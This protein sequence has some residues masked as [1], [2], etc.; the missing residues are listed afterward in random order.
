MIADY[1]AEIKIV[2]FQSVL[3][4]QCHEWRLLS[5]CGRI[6]AKIACFNSVNSEITGQK[7]HLICTS[8]RHK[9]FQL[10]AGT[11]LCPQTDTMRSCLALT[12]SPPLLYH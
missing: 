4:R 7:M 10:Q 3:K 12:M 9:C 2:I 1:S 8:G 6:A 5:N 11:R